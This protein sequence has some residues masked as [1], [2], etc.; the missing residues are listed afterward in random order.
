M[1]HD[2][3]TL[4]MER[5]PSS[6]NDQR[7]VVIRQMA[8]LESAVRV[9]LLQAVAELDECQ[10]WQE[11]G[12]TSMAGWL[13]A[14]CGMSFGTAAELVRVAH[15]LGDLPEIRAGLAE[16]R[17]GWDQVRAL[18]GLA[19]PAL[20]AMLAEQARGLSVAQIRAL[21]RRSRPV[22]DAA[23]GEGHAGRYLRWRWDPDRTQLRLAGRLAGEGAQTVVE[24]LDRFAR[25]VPVNPDT[26]TFDAWEQRCADALVELAATRSPASDRATMVVHVDADTLVGGEGPVEIEHG[27]SI[28]VETARRLACDASVQWVR[29]GVDGRPMGVGRTTRRIPPWL[30]RALEHRDHGC[31]WPGCGRARWTHAH[32]IVHWSQEGPTDLDNLAILCGYHH[33]LVHEGGWTIHGHP[34]RTLRFRR[35]DGKVLPSEPTPVRADLLARLLPGAGPD[36]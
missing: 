32:H 30:R 3:L 21:V 36:P 25:E 20:D 29:D 10:G 31:R 5:R 4:I 1:L 23:A 19:T 33:R 13:T 15:A 7:T 35:K 12:A 9:R 14:F 24:A 11:D 22:D 28:T 27:P 26:G 16:G 17:L 18:V 6:T 2:T 34:G 8:A